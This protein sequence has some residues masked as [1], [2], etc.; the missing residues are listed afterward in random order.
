MHVCISTGSIF[1]VEKKA[2]EWY[3]SGI[4]M[5]YASVLPASVHQVCPCCSLHI[6]LESV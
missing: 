1:S 2:L 3:G 4:E 5:V 6:G